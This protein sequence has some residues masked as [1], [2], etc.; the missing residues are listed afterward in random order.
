MRF[1]ELDLHPDLLRAVDDIGWEE[2]TEIQADAI[3][4]ALD[5][6]DILACAMT[7]SGKTAAFLLPILHRFLAEPGRGTRALVLAPTRELAAQVGDHLEQM[8]YYTDFAGI[9]VTGGTPMKPQVQA[10]RHGIEF[11]I[12]TPGRLLD[13]MRR[14]N[15]RLDELEVLVV[16]EADRMLDMGFLPDVR[17]ILDRLPPDLQTYFLSATLPPPI[18]S[19][20]HE[21]LHE[22]VR[23]NVERK[24]APASGIT[25]AVY[26]VREVMKR[27]LLLD[28]L[29]QDG[30]QSALVFTR[31]KSGADRLADFLERNEIPCRKIHG[32]LNQT[33]R[34]RALADFK[35]GSFRI[36]VATDIAA[37]GLDI[38][39]I[40]HVV[41]FDIPQTPEDYIHRVGRTARADATGDAVTLVCGKELAALHTIEDALGYRLPRLTLDDFDYEGEP[42]DAGLV[43]LADRI[44][45]AESRK[46]AAR[47][48][49]PGNGSSKKKRRRRKRRTPKKGD[50]KAMDR[51]RGA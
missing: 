30:Y 39:D 28:L 48:G 21:I 42:A 33:Q 2:A 26:R 50:P 13:H 4:H 10:L 14:G 25:H 5:G 17:D 9:V 31:T 3:P 27:S 29:R 34:N 23:I 46:K 38:A 35:G 45:A 19:L 20:S 49:D 11:V 16:D 32:D 8:A 44:A 22:P 1:E 40:S 12:A 36:L 51:G 37:R 24:A 6:R 15:A 47:P 18:V 41:N 7:G 43:C